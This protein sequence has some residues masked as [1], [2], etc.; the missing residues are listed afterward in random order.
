M[1]NILTEGL[2]ALGIPAER[3]AVETL[4]AYGRLLADANRVTNLTA[5]TDPA[6]MARLHFLDSAALL[7]VAD[8]SGKRVADV[9]TG[10]GFPGVP[11]RVLQS[12]IRLTV[13]DSV[14][15]KVDFVE[16]S[17][18][19]LGI[20]NVNC[21]WGRAEELPQLREG[22]DIV[23]SRAVA[24]LD[25]LAELCLPMVGRDGLFIAMK[26]PDCQ[27]EADEAD[28]AIRTLGGRLREIRPYTIPGTDVTHAALVVE[29]TASTPIRYPRRY[30]QIKKNP[31]RG[32]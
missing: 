29:K 7:T 10:A 22:F 2:E 25:V 6:D 17:C 16:A 3:E 20:E 11:L 31:L 19:R 8:F 13:M 26:G 9:G 30:A 23:V 4:A 14:G 27:A 5:I 21:I 28:F 32:V 1:E 12:D 15:K 24:E 18:R